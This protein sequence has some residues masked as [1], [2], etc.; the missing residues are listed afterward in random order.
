MKEASKISRKEFVDELL[1]ILREEPFRDPA[2][3]A[4]RSGR[5]SREGVKRWTLQAMFVV[6]EFTRF[7]SAIHSNCP[8]RDAQSLLAEN[9]WEEHGRGAVSRDHFSLVKR[10]ARSLGA[11]DEEIAGAAP[12]PEATEYINFCF[13]ITRNGSFVEGMAAIGIGIEYFM[14]VF[15][16]ALA[17][18][19]RNHYKLSSDDV[20]YLL[21]H[22]AEDED[23]A[24]RSM[25][26]IEQYANTEE[27][28][29][30]TRQAMRRM[31]AIKRRFAEA[32]YAHMIAG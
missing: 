10:M 8:D 6:R 22:V 3:D 26:L 24:R 18:A 19:L 25:E 27:V 21:V 12:L 23:H 15:F 4:I 5:M 2:F 20:A 16:G 1:R 31:L 28:K 32:L 13:E 7:I 14:P 30:K 17:D 9:L 11:T 29:E